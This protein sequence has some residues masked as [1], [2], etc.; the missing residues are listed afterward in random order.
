MIRSHRIT[1]FSKKHK[2]TAAF[3]IIIVWSFWFFQNCEDLTTKYFANNSKIKPPVQNKNSISTH[4]LV[5]GGAG[6]IGSHAS[7]SL[8]EL[9]YHVLIADDMSRGSQRALETLN[10]FSKFRFLKIDLGN[11]TAVDALFQENVIHV[12]MHFAGFAFVQESI[13]HPLRYHDNIVKVTQVVADAMRRYGVKKIIYSSSCAVYGNPLFLPITEET[14]TL[15]IS[16][17]GQSKLDAEKYLRKASSEEFQVFVLRYFNVVGADSRGRLGE[18]PRESLSRYKRIWT[19]CVSVALGKEREIIIGSSV[20]SPGESEIRDFIHVSDLV[21]AHIAVLSLFRPDK[22]FQISNVGTGQ[23]TSTIEFIENCRIV[24]NI[25]IPYKISASKSGNPSVLY[26]DIGSLQRQGHWRPKYLNLTQ[27]LQTSWN[28]VTKNSAVPNRLENKYDV[29]LVGAGLSSAVLAERHAH[30]LGHSVLVIEKRNHIGGNCYDYIDKETGIRVSKYGVHLFHTKYRRVWEYINRFS[31]WTPWEHRVVAKINDTFVPVPVNIDAVNSLF[32]TNITTEQQ[33]QRWLASQQILP[34]SGKARNSEEVGLERVGRILYDTIFKPY[35]IKQWEKDPSE[36]A[37]TVLGRI[38]VRSNHDDRYFTDEYQALPSHGYTRIFENMFRSPRI[39]VMLNTDFF[40]IRNQLR[41]N[42]LY[43]TGPIDAYFAHKGLG[44]LEYRSLNFQRKVY[45]D[46][47]YFQ[48]RAQVNYP[49][50]KYPFTRIIEYKHLLHQRS[51]HTIV[52]FEYSSA[53]GDPYYPV[54]SQRN[55]KLYA[56]YQQLALAEKNIS[57]VGRLANYK[58]FNMDQTILN[59]LEMF[60]QTFHITNTSN[61][62]NNRRK[63]QPSEPSLAIVISVCREN[64]K[65]LSKWISVLNPQNVFI[66]NKCNKTISFSDER[67]EVVKLPNVGREAQSWL[68][69]LLRTDIT[70]S[71]QNL[72]LQGGAEVPLADVVHRLKST[73][74]TTRIDFLWPRSP[75]FSYYQQMPGCVES[76]EI[77]PNS[78]GT[79]Q[80]FRALFEAF[81]PNSTNV[82][83]EN[84]RCTLRGEFMVT[85]HD[86]ESCLLRIGRSQLH[87]LKSET[88]TMDRP[89][90]IYMLERLYGTL[91]SNSENSYIL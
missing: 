77:S 38:P 26:S 27:S 79:T 43:F 18:N 62:H 64:L 47:K 23:P 46:T 20:Q 3:I 35:T 11:T 9:G 86:I 66:Y 81:R 50:L 82:Q 87:N 30:V 80:R 65:W 48:P 12:V 8:L 15:P 36:L 70:F 90:I 54:P 22:P 17:Y 58:Y 29:C 24:S 52:F 44:T 68:H 7:L 84:L 33:M 49:S 10:S 37:P 78:R 55:Q 1:V 34:H 89:A 83:F 51:N 76:L 91:F 28:H 73:R 61:I 2:L 21:A 74:N 57:F 42:K 75:R 63:S 25:F 56:Q 69:H 5:T 71:S 72:F 53:K 45:L 16:P 31:E 13:E 85:R 41:C 88:E 6:F 59:A 40:D 39:T 67:I 19:A 4:I 14:P 60:D 32:G